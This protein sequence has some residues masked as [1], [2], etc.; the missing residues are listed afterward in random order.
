MIP[1]QQHTITTKP[2]TIAAQSAQ[3]KISGLGS[4][5]TE[6]TPPTI[7]ATVAMDR[8]TAVK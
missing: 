6:T 1:V 7:H 4:L 8:D 2:M 5:N 3:L